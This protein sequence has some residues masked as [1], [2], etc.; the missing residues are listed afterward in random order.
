[1][2]FHQ[3]HAVELSHCQ[4]NRSLR[5]Q[6][7]AGACLLADPAPPPPSKEQQ[8]QQQQPPQGKDAK[9]RLRWTP[10]LHARFV[11]AVVSLDGP[12]KA[13]PKSILKLMAVEGLTIYHIKSHLQ[14]LATPCPTL[15]HMRVLLSCT[16]S[17]SRLGQ[18][19]SF[20]LPLYQTSRA[21]RLPWQEPAWAGG[22]FACMPACS[23][24]L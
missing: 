8:Q 14:V 17:I 2:S 13:T 6:A 3:Q 15:S 16:P 19:C 10:E 21:H 12:D 24:M 9:P 22:L 4:L 1:M 20:T 11:N 18:G 5:C 7:C 23:P